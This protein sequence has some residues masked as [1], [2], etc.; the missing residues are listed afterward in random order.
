MIIH[1]GRPIVMTDAVAGTATLEDAGSIASG[2]V[3]AL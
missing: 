3:G 2:I 1:S